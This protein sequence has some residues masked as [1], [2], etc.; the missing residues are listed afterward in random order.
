MRHD[1]VH[2]SSLVDKK[3]TELRDKNGGNLSNIN[4]AFVF[5]FGPFMSMES[6]FEHDCDEIAKHSDV[7]KIFQFAAYLIRKITAGISYGDAKNEIKNFI[8]EVDDVFPEGTHK[9]V[10]DSLI[11]FAIAYKNSLREEQ[12]K[13]MESFITNSAPIVPYEGTLK[14]QPLEP[15]FEH[16]IDCATAV[17]KVI[18]DTQQTK[19]GNHDALLSILLHNLVGIMRW[20]DLTTMIEDPVTGAN[21]LMEL[22]H[23][24]IDR[25][26]IPYGVRAYYFLATINYYGLPIEIFD[27]YLKF[28]AMAGDFTKPQSYDAFE[29][30]IDAM[31]ETVNTNIAIESWEDPEM[32][33]KANEL[34]EKACNPGTITVPDD[35][36]N[37]DFNAFLSFIAQNHS[38]QFG[39]WPKRAFIAALHDRKVINVNNFVNNITIYELDNNV[40]V[41]PFV[42]VL[43]YKVR[44][45]TQGTKD[46]RLDIC[47]LTGAD[48]DSLCL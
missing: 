40:M 46:A 14:K 24:I 47:E 23:L 33:R 39:E 34:Y 44:L 42:D 26:D 13:N 11:E 35:T 7:M 28:F 45:L 38:M 1:V 48:F 37:H 20:K 30:M 22:D 12:G 25:G 41:C 4:D 36:A 3:L 8:I 10:H 19:G 16:R 27:K 2:L 31:A 15:G 5:A 21:N 29:A 18:V 32:E 9:N 43:D 6:G 17:Q